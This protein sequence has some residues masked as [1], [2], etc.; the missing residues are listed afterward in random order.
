MFGAVDPVLQQAIYVPLVWGLLYTFSIHLIIAKWPAV[1]IIHRYTILEYHGSDMY[2]LEHSFH[3]RKMAKLDNHHHMTAD[4]SERSAPDKIKASRETDQSV[5]EQN[6]SHLCN[7]GLQFGQLTSSWHRLNQ[8]KEVMNAGGICPL[9][10]LH[11]S[12]DLTQ[13][14]EHSHM[15]SSAAFKPGIPSSHLDSL[16]Q[17]METTG[18]PVYDNL[19]ALV[20][21]IN[22]EMRHSRKAQNRQNISILSYNI[23]N[24]N[25]VSGKN[26]AYFNRIKSLGKVGFD[27]NL[28]HNYLMYLT[29]TTKHVLNIFLM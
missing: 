21:C 12:C 14:D 17:Q 28:I 9:R 23:W 3:L 4:Q 8:Y 19:C 27:I 5:G 13:D 22:G 2:V 20:G 18:E 26:S 15:Y 16:S 1:E 29:L 6:K 11:D 25:S 10:G 7:A 24:M